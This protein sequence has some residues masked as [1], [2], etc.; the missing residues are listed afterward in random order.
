MTQSYNIILCTAPN[1]NFCCGIKVISLRIYENLNPRQ[2]KPTSS[3]HQNPT[4]KIQ[5]ESHL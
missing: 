4:S 2:T 5:F 1:S 3:D